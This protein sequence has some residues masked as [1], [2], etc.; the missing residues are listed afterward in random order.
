MGNHFFIKAFKHCPLPRCTSSIGFGY[1]FYSCFPTRIL[2]IIQCLSLSIVQALM[3]HYAMFTT[4]SI[5]T[6][7]HVHSSPCIPTHLHL[8]QTYVYTKIY[9]KTNHGNNSSFFLKFVLLLT[10]FCK[11]KLILIFQPTFF[12][13]TI[14]CTLGYLPFPHLWLCPFILSF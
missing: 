11:L 12:E 2:N 5:W 8:H 4:V 3:S 14:P 9:S 10:S 1:Y 6:Y 7:Q 13:I